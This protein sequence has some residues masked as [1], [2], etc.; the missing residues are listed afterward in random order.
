MSATEPPDWG[1]T[2]VVG[3][4]FVAQIGTLLWASLV[5]GPLAGPLRAGTFSDPTM[6]GMFCSAFV[7]WFAY[8]A[9]PIITTR[10]RGRGPV[11]DLRTVVRPLDVPIGLAAGAFLQYPVLTALYFPILRIV[12]GDPSAA[13]EELNARASGLTAKILLVVLA[14]VMAPLV[15]ELF[16]RG[17]MLRGLLKRFGPGVSVVVQAVVFA[18]IHFQPLQFPGLL[19]VGLVSGVVALRTNRLGIC[20]ALHAGFNG[21]TLVLL[22][23]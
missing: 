20:W 4:F 12:D 9:G 6:T 13:A 11:H 7:L 8:G 5:F 14:G 22:F 10:T 19:L 17:F 21:L 23:N 3:W 15:E 18:A 2:E 16:F 1:L